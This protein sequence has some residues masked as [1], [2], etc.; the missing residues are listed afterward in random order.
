MARTNYMNPQKIRMKKL[1]RYIMG[2]CQ[3]WE[4]FK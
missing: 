2:I 1:S 3:H 4:K